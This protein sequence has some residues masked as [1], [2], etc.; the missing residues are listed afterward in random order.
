[1]E[2]LLRKAGLRTLAVRGVPRPGV[3]D[4][5][6]AAMESRLKDSRGRFDALIDEGGSG[7]EP[8]VYLFAKGA[9]EAAALALRLARAYSARQSP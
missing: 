6:V 1:M 4:P 5:T 7:I 2:A 8:N 9:H 3:E